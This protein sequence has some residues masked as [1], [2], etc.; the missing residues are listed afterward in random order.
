VPDPAPGEAPRAKLSILAW[1][2]YTDWASLQALGRA[3]EDLGFD[4][5]WSWDH[6]YPINGE[7]DGPIF[8]GYLTV[9]GWTAVTST[10]PLGLL[11]TANTF[12]QP[13]LV[14]KMATT[15]DHM[16]GGRMVLGLGAAWFEPEHVAYGIEFGPWVGARLDWLDEAAMLIRGMLDG[17]R[18][19]GRRFYD[20]KDV[21]N[22]PAPLQPRLPLLIG[23]GGEKKTLATVARY[24][25]MWNVDGPLEDL[26]RKNEVLKRWC[27]E[28]G[29]DEREIER[30][31][32]GGAV[33]VRRTAAEARRVVAEIQRVNRWD[34]EPELV[35]TPDQIAD[36]LAPY[37]ELGFHHIDFDYPAPY[38]LE[39]L[40]LL[41]AEVRPRLDDRLAALGF[42]RTGR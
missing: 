35:G 22:E 28:V 25:D 42:S 38:D 27:A 11:V 17:L 30:T 19:S 32:G 20:A 26:R 8:E 31:M 29:R 7:T 3:V 12:R 33:V 13:T 9:A 23:G 1:N 21:V 2:Q 16:S 36:R 14:A 4:A 18:P 5:L 40:E 37:L 41:A 39:T 34:G 15:L 6:L 10:I 24:A